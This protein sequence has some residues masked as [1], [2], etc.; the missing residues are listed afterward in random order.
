MYF[1]QDVGAMIEARNAREWE[2]QNTFIAPDYK[3]IDTELEDALESLKTAYQAIADAAREA[4]GIP[5]EYR[6]SS[7]LGDIDVIRDDITSLKARLRE[8]AKSA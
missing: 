1:G 7:L 5:G 8:E 6:I 4:E 3:E 2:A